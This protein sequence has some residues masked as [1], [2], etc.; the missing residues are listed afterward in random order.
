MISTRPFAAKRQTWA[1]IGVLILGL[2][3]ARVIGGWIAAEDLKSVTFAALGIAVIVIGVAIIR[4][5]RAGFYIFIA[6][7]LYEDF[8]RKY[9]GNNMVIYFAKDALTAILYFSFFAAVRRRRA[10]LPRFPFLIFVNFFFWLGV[11]QCFNPSS[12]S[13]LYG[14]LGLK[15]YFFYIPLL[16]VGYALIRTDE[17]LHRFLIINMM[18]AGPIAALGIIQSIVGPSFLNPTVLAPDIRELSTLYRMAPI[19]GAILYQPNSVFVSAGRF[20]A[21]LLI[22]WLLGLGGAGYLLLGRRR[23]QSIVFTSMALVAVAAI[24]CGG[25]GAM[26]YVLGSGLV[27]AAA[28]LWGA[29]RR[30]RQSHRLVKAI[31]RATAVAGIAMLITVFFFPEAVGARWSY[32]EETILPTS[33]SEQ[34]TRRLESYPVQEFE[35]AI[36]SGGWVLGHGIGTASLGVQYVSRWIG[37]KRPEFGVE[38][39]YGNI[40]IEYGILGPFLWLI[41]STAV[42]IY[43]WKV[44]R[45][46][47]ETVYFPL[48]FAIFWFALLL[49]YPMTYGTLNSYEDYIY[50]AY[51][52]LLIG[53][54]FRLPTLASESA[55]IARPWVAV[56]HEE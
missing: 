4:D 53:V 33:P 18:L 47:R 34:L 38:S 2:W 17:D 50:N 20:D 36:D 41:W 28:L 46:M 22:P 35:K 29:P 19:T 32:Y 24:M 39:G 27:L 43:A 8:V 3:T 21:Y 51:F 6:W 7:L 11:L 31:W 54:L 42:L 44:V 48:A 1:S 9:M 16:F 52:W 45:K 14:L 13:L 56:V 12:P 10:V 37:Q 23:G 49:L 55:G 40:L 30:W 15:L 26:L 25:R 5:W